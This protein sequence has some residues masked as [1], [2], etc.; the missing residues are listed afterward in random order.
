MDSD[1]FDRIARTWATSS[2]RRM[3]GA[4]AAGAL[5]TLLPRRAGAA[6]Q[7]GSITQHPC[8]TRECIG[9][10]FVN[11]FDP[12]DTVCR[13]A[14]SECDAP[15]FCTGS[16]FACPLDRKRPNGSACTSDG[17]VC[18]DDVCQNG[19]CVHVPNTAACADDGNI[20]T[21]DICAGGR[22]T[23]PP[24]PDDSSCPAGACCGGQCVETRTDEAHC[25]ACDR[26]CGAGKT[27]CKGKC[28]NL[29]NDER[30]CGKCGKRCRRGQTCRR[31]R[32]Q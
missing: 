19:Q 31:G 24:K 9:G 7:E 4:L 8:G 28:V 6:C 11:F 30:N 22:C 16:S 10:E 26:V 12:A 25:G 29:N 23:H 3:V 17:D 5:T 20:C 2:R 13:P 1:R 15:E 14:A 21:D 18:T 32:C 27:C